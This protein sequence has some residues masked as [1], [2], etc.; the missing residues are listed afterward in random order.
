MYAIVFFA[1]CSF[2]S[3]PVR[4]VLYTSQK[5]TLVISKYYIFVSPGIVYKGERKMTTRT[6]QAS[7]KEILTT[8]EKP[9]EFV[10]HSLKMSAQERMAIW[11]QD[12]TW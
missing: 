6:Q 9:Y 5:F 12:T 4:Y 2:Q 7:R 11:D 10:E 3:A 1:A 8:K